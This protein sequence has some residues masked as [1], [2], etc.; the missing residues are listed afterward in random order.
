MNKLRHGTDSMMQ[1]ILK[2]LTGAKGTAGSGNSDML[3]G[4]GDSMGQLSGKI[5]GGLVSGAA[6]GGLMALLMGNKSARKFASKAAGYGGAAVLGGLAFNAYRNWKDQQESAETH[7]G[8]A[9]TAHSGREL[10]D[11][12][13]LQHP[14]TELTLIKAMIAAAKADGHLDQGEQKRI[15]DVVGKMSLSAEAKGTIFDLLQREITIE[16]LLD[17]SASME[18]KS[19]VYLASCLVIDIDHPKER[20]HLDRLARLFELP[21]GLPEQLENEA[22]QALQ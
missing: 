8:T 14:I 17:S 19:E 5:P 13:E 2:T 10:I 4:L 15:H 22:R 16:E 9:A 3:K 1:E 11:P 6:A 20:E 18:Q 12:P 7:A 21:N